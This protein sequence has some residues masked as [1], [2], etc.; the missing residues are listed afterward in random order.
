MANNTDNSNLPPNS[1]SLLRAIVITVVVAAVLL[2]FFVLPAEYGIDPTGV[3]KALGL[4]ELAAPPAKTITVTDILGGNEGI[5]QV[6]I[7][8]AGE[9]TPLPN[10]AVFQDESTPPQTRT[11]QIEIP[12]DGETEVKVKMLTGKVVAFSWQ[13]NQGKVYVDYHGHDP[14]F[15]PDFFVRYK[16]EQESSSGNGTLTAPFGG[17]HGWYWLNFN[18]EPVTITLTVTGYFVDVIDYGL[19]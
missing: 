18:A 10:P 7:G 16:E 9:P 1:G 14:S 4:T 11:L 6:E 13:T 19:F 12:P 8:D 17:E 5:T 3:G 15:G 2:V